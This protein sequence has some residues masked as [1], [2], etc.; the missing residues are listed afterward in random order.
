MSTCTAWPQTPGQGL[1]CRQ[2]GPVQPGP[3]RHC[4]WTGSQEAPLEQEQTWLQLCPYVWA[5]QAAGE[6]GGQ[7]PGGTDPGGAAADSA[8][9]GSV[10]PS[11]QPGHHSGQPQIT[12]AL[13]LG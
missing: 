2:A 4:P 12:L 3:Q 5:G 9:A 11:F 1:P 6:G 10:C 8:Q 13:T 7:G